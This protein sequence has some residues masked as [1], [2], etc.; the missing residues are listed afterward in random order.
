MPCGVMPNL[1]EFKNVTS[2]CCICFS[3]EKVTLEVSGA[4]KNGNFE[5][6]PTVVSDLKSVAV[7]WDILAKKWLFFLDMVV[8]V[9]W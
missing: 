5:A 4:G 6:I 3:E 9:I 8:F 1:V 2:F 7:K